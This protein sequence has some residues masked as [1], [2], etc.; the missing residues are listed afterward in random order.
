M[1]YGL[2][3]VL[4]IMVITATM[5]NIPQ[6]ATAQDAVTCD[7]TLL[8]TATVYNRLPNPIYRIN[9]NGPNLPGSIAVV[10]TKTWITVQWTIQGPGTWDSLY[11]EYSDAGQGPWIAS[12]FKVTAVCSAA[13]CDTLVP[14]PSTAIVGSITDNAA[15][16]GMPQ[17]DAMTNNVLTVGKT[18][19]MDGLDLT[20]TY[21]RVLVSCTWA[22]VEASKTGPNYDSIWNGT[23]LPTH[24]VN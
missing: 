19:W 24:T 1:K 2:R 5:G 22:W 6:P 10:F 7:G 21:R 12:S 14:I 16:F 17:A 18:F 20:R 15:I 11:V 13:G 4:L 23:P 3:F 9:G 8:V